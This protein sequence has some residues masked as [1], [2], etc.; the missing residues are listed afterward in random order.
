MPQKTWAVG[1]E[2]LAADFNTYVQNQVVPVF[3][4]EAQ[5]DAQWTSP[6]NGAQCLTLDAF[7]VWVRQ[8]GAWV[9][10]SGVRHGGIVTGSGSIAP[11]GVVPISNMVS[12]VMWNN[13]VP[14]A[15]GVQVGKTGL[16]TCT[17]ELSLTTGVVPS[18]R[19]WGQISTAPAVGT[20]RVPVIPVGE[21][22]AAGSALLA[23][24][25]GGG[26]VGVSIFHTM[27]AATA[28]TVRLTVG[29]T[30]P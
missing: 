3:A 14:W 19:C 25:A 17:L 4:T 30:A 8:A 23:F 28:F 7:T 21:G 6:P 15:S 26:Q 20:F 1:E 9:I 13:A 16:Y 29:Q 24:P 11:G 12:E 2:V 27:P 22:S 5:R 18:G 10:L